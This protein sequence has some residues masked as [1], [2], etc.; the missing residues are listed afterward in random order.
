VAAG[1]TE[2]KA[3]AGAEEP[4]D[5]APRSGTCAIVGRPNVGKSTLLNALVGQKLA[6][7]TERPGTTRTRL[8]GVH[9]ADDPPTQIA[10]IDTPG[11]TRPRG[12][13]GQ[14]L[15]EEVDASLDE[16]DV[17]LLVT[18][19]PRPR[20]GRSTTG[21]G[22]MG[23]RSGSA[24]GTHPGD[25]GLINRLRDVPAPLVLAINKVD[26]VGDKSRLLPL[27]TAYADALPFAG[28]VPISAA[29]GDQLPALVREIRRQLPTGLAFDP[30][31]LTD[32]P[33]RFFAA[34]LVRE[35]ALRHTRAEVPYGIAVTI[36]GWESDGALLRIRG[37]LVVEKPSHKGIVIGAGGSRLKAIGTEARQGIEALVDRRVH[38]ELWV[39][40]DPGWTGDPRRARALTR[41]D[42]G[43]AGP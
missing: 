15:R 26:L 7:A 14:V 20:G 29:T 24:P 28:L 21:R 34:E 17:V 10:F 35:A 6:I 32:R 11:L 33:E 36:D 3:P 30:E 43:A 9:V 19:P 16:A 23:R 41:G 40:V 2:G 38:L 27:L 12:A 31:L 37:T 8:L 5:G 13:L 22:G 1:V 4:E 39:R 25:A 42:E 18:D